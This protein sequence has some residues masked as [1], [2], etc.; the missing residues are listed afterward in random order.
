MQVRFSS[1]APPRC[2][3]AMVLL[4]ITLLSVP[5]LATIFGSVRG[6]V[7][8][9]QHHPVGGATVILQASDSA[10]KQESK[11][12]AEGE[13]SF[14]AVPL[15]KYS[16]TVQAAGFAEQSQIFTVVSGQAPVLHYQ[17]ALASSEGKRHRHCFP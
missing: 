15:G 1:L 12:T 7:H 9:P 6:V 10:Y 8:D 5:G 3:W 16:V 11:T 4:V 2:A 17:L 13:F 14:S